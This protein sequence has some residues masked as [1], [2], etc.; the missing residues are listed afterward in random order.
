MLKMFSRKSTFCQHDHVDK[1]GL[2]FPIRMPFDKFSII[3]TP[4]IIVIIILFFIDLEKI[5]KKGVDHPQKRKENFF[6]EI[7]LR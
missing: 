5:K 2:K 7:Q 3:S 1:F 6:Y 4:L